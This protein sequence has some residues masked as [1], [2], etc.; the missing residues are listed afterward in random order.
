MIETALAAA[1]A[2][3][4]GVGRSIG[5]C[6]CAPASP[7]PYMEAEDAVAAWIDERCE[8]NSSAWESSTVLFASWSAWAE[9]AG[10]NPGPQLT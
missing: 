5:P 8:R 2:I 9:L 7:R 10:E 4:A 3:T 1:V 6:G